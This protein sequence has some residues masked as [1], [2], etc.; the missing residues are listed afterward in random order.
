MI[1]N[2]I[3]AVGS[4]WAAIALWPGTGLVRGLAGGFAGL[5][6]WLPF[7]AASSRRSSVSPVVLRLGGFA[8]NMEDF[9]RGWLITGQLGTGKTSGAINTMLWQVSKNCPLWGGVCVDDKGL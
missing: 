2:L 7:C 5:S 8:W 6:L 4:A 3:L 1:G 9:C